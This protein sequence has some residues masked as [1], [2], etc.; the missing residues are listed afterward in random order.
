MQPNSLSE[1]I[2][3]FV[4]G[5]GILQG[6]LL[7]AI[8]Y[9]HPRADRSV[10]SFLALYIICTTGVMTLPFIM[11]AFSW[12]KS[13]FV[14]PLPLLPG[15]LLYLYMR[16][17]KEIITWKKLLPHFIPFCLFFFLAYWNL[18]AMAAKFPGASE[19]PAEVLHHPVTITLVYIKLGQLLCYYFLAR[20]TLL[21]YQRSIQQLFSETSRF[22]LQWARL[23]INGYLM[24]IVTSLLLISLM[25][26]Y[27]EHFKLLLL[28]DMAIATPYMYIATFK[29]IMQPTIWQLQ[30]GINK[31]TVEEEMLEAEEI[32][33]E[34]N[35]ANHE[36]SSPSN[37]SKPGLNPGK[38]NGI[39]KRIIAL[40]EEEKLYQETELTLQQ[41]ADKLKLPPYQL[42]QAINE[43]L[44]KNFYDLINGYRVEEAKRLLLESKSKNYTILS[45]GFEAGFNSKTTF[46]TVFKKM[47]GQTPTGF[48]VQQTGQLREA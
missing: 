18:S 44:N 7:A 10:N 11:Q 32:E 23:L 20:K 45:I 39:T 42:S 29:G 21:S 5:I 19:M 14:Q 30:P 47:T 28:I 48:I 3:L 33:T 27:P 13:F 22:D 36:N 40:M 26:R 4:C 9:F 17:F 46:N 31:E 2:L 15:P 24:L 37:L 12:Q 16:S 6:I 38:I 41:L 34:I 43:G 1:T 8:I 35:R 25:I